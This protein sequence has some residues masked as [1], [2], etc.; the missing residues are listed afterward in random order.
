[1]SLGLWPRIVKLR[2]E[3]TKSFVFN[4][5]R[6]STR[7]SPLDRRLVGFTGKQQDVRCT[8]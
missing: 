1:M 3:A 4:K 6:V 2:N 5:T 8:T 7:F